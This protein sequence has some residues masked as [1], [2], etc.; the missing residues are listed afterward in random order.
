MFSVISVIIGMAMPSHRSFIKDLRGLV[1]SGANLWSVIKY[2]LAEMYG[3]FFC[4]LEDLNFMIPP[5]SV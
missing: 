4:L 3:R 1:K 5:F 2:R